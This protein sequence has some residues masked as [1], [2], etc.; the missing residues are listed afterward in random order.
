VDEFPQ[1][2]DQA[3]RQCSTTEPAVGG[4]EGHPEWHTMPAEFIGFFD[5]DP[6]AVCLQDG[7]G[8]GMK[9]GRGELEGLDAFQFGD[10]LEEVVQG[11]TPGGG[12]QFLEQGTCVG[13][14][15]GVRG[16]GRRFSRT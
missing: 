5:R 2:I 4:E 1:E 11:R 13:G 9:Q 10:F 8:E 14:G 12:P 7:R 3:I 16:G 15:G 6:L